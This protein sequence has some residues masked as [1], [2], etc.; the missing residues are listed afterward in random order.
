VVCW[1]CVLSS[2]DRQGDSLLTSAF[3]VQLFAPEHVIPHQK[4]VLQIT[5]LQVSASP[6]LLSNASERTR[7][8]GLPVHAATHHGK[9]GLGLLCHLQHLPQHPDTSH[10]VSQAASVSS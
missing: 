7:A 10:K 4:Y 2:R 3:P 5:R 6:S 8:P 1:V 9:L